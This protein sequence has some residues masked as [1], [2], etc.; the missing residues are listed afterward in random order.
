MYFHLDGN[1]A[2]Q[3]SK[4]MAYFMFT[5]SQKCDLKNIKKL[6]ILFGSE[7]GVWS[8][9]YLMIWLFQM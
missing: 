6:H 3:S 4:C 2:V 9:A 5:V 7:I 8:L 1:H